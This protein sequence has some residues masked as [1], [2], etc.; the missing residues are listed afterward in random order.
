MRVL[1]IKLRESLENY[2][3]IKFIIIIIYVDIFDEYFLYLWY[4]QKLL[5]FFFI[6]MNTISK[7]NPE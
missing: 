6:P 3:F 1:R 7:S 5:K 2:Y 4:L